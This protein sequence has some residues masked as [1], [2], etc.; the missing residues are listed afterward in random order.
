MGVR[1]WGG[2]WGRGM[3]VRTGGGWGHGGRIWPVVLMASEVGGV[4]VRH[5][6]GEW[7]SGGVRTWGSGGVRT[8]GS[9]G[10]GAWESN[11]ASSYTFDS[12]SMLWCWIFCFVF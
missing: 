7:G 4:G 6:G 11:T 5:G 9:G 1:S 10:V 8:W 2:E 12:F 3:G